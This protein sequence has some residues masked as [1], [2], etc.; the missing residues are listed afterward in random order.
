MKNLNFVCAT[1]MLL[2]VAIAG[3][4]GAQEQQFPAERSQPKTCDAIKWNADMLRAHPGLIDAC[5]E[6]IVTDSG[7]WARF[8]A[9]FV[10]VEPDGLVIFSVRDRTDRSLEQVRLMPAAGQ[11][12]YLDDRPVPFRQLRTTDSVNLYVP[13]G[14]Y[15]FA[16]RPAGPPEK[17]AVVVP[18]ATTPTATAPVAQPPMMAQQASLPAALPKTAGP[19]PWVALGGLLS[20]LTGLGLTLRRSR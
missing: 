17:L 12:A 10:R 3:A 20:L 6:V 9:K 4:A 8:Q 16:T 13:E 1:A 19:L 5:R 18:A 11:V 7:T 2:G 15:G 14:Q